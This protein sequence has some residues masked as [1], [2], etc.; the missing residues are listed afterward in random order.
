MLKFLL[1]E[2]LSYETAV[3][4]KSLGYDVK[5]VVDFG[6]SGAEDSSVTERATQERRTLITLD[7]DFGEM[8]Y[9]GTHQEFSVIILRLKN[10]TVESVNGVLDRLLASEILEQKNLG[11]TLIIVDE[12]RIR[13]RNRL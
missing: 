3:F 6:L 7:A 4:L 9:F 13:V 5:T 2:N 8:F 11:N 10:Q 12:K 1:D